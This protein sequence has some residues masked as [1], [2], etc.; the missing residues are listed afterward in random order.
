MTWKARL[1][2]EFYIDP[3][4]G[5]MLFAIL[6]GIVGALNYVLRSTVVKVKFVLSG[7]KAE[8]NQEKIPF[9][10]FSDNK[11]YWNVFE[12]VCREMDERGID[13]SYLTASP[14]DPAL[15]CGLEHVHAAF[16]GEGNA[17]FAK[18]NLLKATV[19]LSTTPGLDV[20]QWKRSPDVDCYVHMFHSAGEA[21]MYRMFGIDYYDAVLLTGAE[22]AKDIREMEAARNLPEK[23]LHVCG[24]PY[25]DE[26]HKR[27]VEAGPVPAHERTVL[28]APSWGK[29]ALFGKYG[30]DIIGKL[31]ATGYHVIVRPHPQSFTSE[32]EMIEAIMARY[33]ESSQLEWN[34]YLD[35]FEVLRR[36]D[37][38]VSD[39]SGVVMDFALV[40][41]KPVIYT[42]AEIDKDPYDA[43]WFKGQTWTERT[44]PRIGTQLDESALDDLKGTIDRCLEDPSFAQR[45][46]EV[47]DEAWQCFGH[48]ARETVDYLVEKRKRVLAE[49]EAKVVEGP[50][51]EDGPRRRRRKHAGEAARAQQAKSPA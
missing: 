17:A 13:V 9:A 11:R 22:E 6:I 45:R 49:T 31:L 39:F 42:E 14:D 7:G 35:N 1:Y 32:T 51:Q 26:M 2:M 16:L 33:P 40:Y 5:S 24:V 18:L 19:V 47:R 48:G 30:G 21:K 20:Y 28:L 44:L 38:L 25:M 8:A 12:P 41:D 50:A 36:S 3:G 46:Q 4:T 15:E 43:W 29:S 34:R 27:L 10:V 23:E 37:I